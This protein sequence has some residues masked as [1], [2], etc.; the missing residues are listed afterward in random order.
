MIFLQFIMKWQEIELSLFVTCFIISCSV[1]KHVPFKKVHAKY[2]FGVLIDMEFMLSPLLKKS[3][4]PSC[5]I[6]LH[7]IDL[8]KESYFWNH[9]LMY[10][11]IVEW[12]SFKFCLFFSVI[13]PIEHLKREMIGMLLSFLCILTFGYLKL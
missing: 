6:H 7:S 3:Y 11:I 1:V 12:K 2:Y 9:I 8:G 4:F 5:Y 13:L 10:F